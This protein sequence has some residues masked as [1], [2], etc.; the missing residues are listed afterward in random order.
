M[1]KLIQSYFTNNEPI[2]FIKKDVE[3]DLSKISVEKGLFIYFKNLL[4]GSGHDS[5]S[6][7]GIDPYNGKEIA[8]NFGLNKNKIIDYNKEGIIINKLSEK[9]FIQNF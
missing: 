6:Y 1:Q 2:T 7:Y 3:P 5:R 8:L 4:L 9:N